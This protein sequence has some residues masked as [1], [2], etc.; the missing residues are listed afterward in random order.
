MTFVLFTLKA[1]ILMVMA[2]LAF[3]A[4]EVILPLIDF[5][6]LS[7]ASWLEI[8]LWLMLAPFP[9]YVFFIWAYWPKIKSYCLT[10]LSDA[11]EPV[12]VKDDFTIVRDT[13]KE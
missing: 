5:S 7:R 9:I 6:E 11:L 13:E 4:P 8:T 1:A 2:F 12:K 10:G 3:K